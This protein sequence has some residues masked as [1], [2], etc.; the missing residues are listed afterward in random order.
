[1]DVSLNI[2]WRF[3]L[4]DKI[5]V[6]N[7]KSSWGYICSDKHFKL[8]LSES[9]QCDL[10]LILSDVSVQDLDLAHAICKNDLIRIVLGLSENDSLTIQ[11][12][13]A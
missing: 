11:T 3:K 8:A 4:D 12:F 7:V 13:V 2:L 1:M 9:F 10:S 5:N 6:R